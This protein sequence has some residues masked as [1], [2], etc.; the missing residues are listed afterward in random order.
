M[1]EWI[2]TH[3][4]VRYCYHGTEPEM[5]RIEDIA[6][7]LSNICR[8]AGH[9]SKFYSVAEHS[10]RVSYVCPEAFQLQGLLHDASEAYCVDIPRPLKNAPGMDIYKGYEKVSHNVIAEVFGLPTVHDRSVDVA[11]VC[12]LYTEKR[13]LMPDIPWANESKITGLSTRP[14]MSVIDPWSPEQAKIKFL[15]R[16]YE[17]T[18]TKEFYNYPYYKTLGEI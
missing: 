11:D 7:A 14:L 5:I 1:R 13:D 8:F 6:H 17:L 15:T 18:G 12:L 3:T 9:V 2:S 4:G 16:F 10:V